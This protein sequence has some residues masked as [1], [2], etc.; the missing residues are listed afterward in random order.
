MH[1]VDITP[2]WSGLLPAMLAA[3]ENGKPETRRAMFEELSRMARAA[4]AHVA[5]V[6]A[7]N[8]GT[9]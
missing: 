2:T 4:D 5:S 7:S 3:Y 1:T 9:E 8:G 6:K